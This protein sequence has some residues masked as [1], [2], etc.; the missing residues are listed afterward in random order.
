MTKESSR[1]RNKQQVTQ[2]VVQYRGQSAHNRK[3]EENL[4]YKLGHSIRVYTVATKKNET[5]NIIRTIKQKD[6]VVVW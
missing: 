1:S 5:Q 6:Y 3:Q 2:L 4:L